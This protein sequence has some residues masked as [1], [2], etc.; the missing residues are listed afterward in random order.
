M[1]VFVYVIDCGQGF[2]GTVS[3]SCKGQRSWHFKW[4]RFYSYC[5]VTIY[6]TWISSITMAH[7]RKHLS[8]CMFPVLGL[9][10]D[11]VKSTTVQTLW[12]IIINIGL[13][14]RVFYQW[15]WR[16]FPSKTENLSTS[17]KPFFMYDIMTP[18]RSGWWVYVIFPC[19]SGGNCL[20]A[21]FVHVRCGDRCQGV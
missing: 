18:M 11:C 3:Y 7:G 2:I 16:I 4:S 14:M 12:G 13:E 5:L 17:F 8:C 9:N 15:I 1:V 21:H 6:W 19:W 20:A 10:I